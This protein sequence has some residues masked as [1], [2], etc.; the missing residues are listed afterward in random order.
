ML[1]PF[2]AAIFRGY[3]LMKVIVLNPPSK[4]NKNVMRDVIYGCWCRGRRIGGLKLP[5]IG[6][7]LIATLLREETGFETDFLDAGLEGR[8]YDETIRHCAQY[9]VIIIST[10]THTFL[11]DTAVLEDIKKINEQCITIVHGP[12]PS[13][14][15]ESVLD[16]KEID[17]AVKMEPEYILRDVCRF[18]AAGTDAWKEVKGIGFRN[19]DSKVINDPHPMIQ[20]L[21]EIPFPDRT[22]LPDNVDYFN[23]VAK[24]NPMTTILTSRGCPAKCTFC[25]SPY[26]FGNKV[27]C[28]SAENVLEELELISRQG[29]KEVFFRDETFTAFKK[30]NMV[31]CEEMLKR[32]IDLTWVCNARVDLIDKEMMALMKKAG[33]HYIKFGIESG[34]QRILDTIQKGYVMEDA[35]KAFENAARAGLKTHAHFMIGHPGETVEDVKLSLKLMIKLK[36]TT[37]SCGIMMLYPGTPQFKLLSSNF[38]EA[39]DPS[40][41]DFEKD[42]S[43]YLA[44]LNS[45]LSK[46]Q[47]EFF[48]KKAYRQ[49]YLRPDYLIKR[50]LSI[51]SMD[52]LKQLI[53]AG[54]QIFEYSFFGEKTST[55]SKS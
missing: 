38:S 3:G 9:D 18:L 13:F 1:S 22:L 51:G 6:Q 23:P 12:R 15:T 41:S 17:M 48:V 45:E 36:P 39:F 24:R 53:L 43:A 34:S 10:S 5:P 19:G 47:I 30:R 21:D 54:T 35:H 42:D 25:L 26:F 44:S 40:H 7:L 2:F 31:I 55:G 46:E 50:L 14:L 28:R 20:N 4:T 33:C 27:R 52:E 16:S 32:K 37:I 8:G 29:Y 11:Q 49:F